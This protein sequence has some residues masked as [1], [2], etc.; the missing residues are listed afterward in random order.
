MIQSEDWELEFLSFVSTSKSASWVVFVQFFQ[1]LNRAQIQ[2]FWKAGGTKQKYDPKILKRGTQVKK[3]LIEN[4]NY[5][6]LSQK[7]GHCPQAPP[8]IPPQDPYKV[9]GNQEIDINLCKGIWKNT[10]VPTTLQH[11]VPCMVAD[12]ISTL[13]RVSHMLTKPVFIHFLIQSITLFYYYLNI[14]REQSL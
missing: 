12:Q 1:K 4:Q 9:E 11:S 8:L 5:K 14:F 13:Y 10:D 3:F 7:G 6:K 2:N